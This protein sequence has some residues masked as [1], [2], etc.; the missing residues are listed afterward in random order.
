MRLLACAPHCRTGGTH[1]T[2]RQSFERFVFDGTTWT[3]WRRDGVKIVYETPNETPATAYRWSLARVVGTHGNTVTYS[4]DC[5]NHCYLGRI[6]YAASGTP[7]GAA[8][9]PA[10]KAGAD[11]RFIY[12][13]R[14]DI[15]TYPTGKGTAQIRQRLRTIEVRMDDH[16][17]AAYALEYATNPVTEN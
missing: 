16:L 15:V 13:P 4:Q 3:R 2:R 8:G 5:P 1:E 14:R 6:T 7:C 10:C 17:V 9:Q 11:I 12:E